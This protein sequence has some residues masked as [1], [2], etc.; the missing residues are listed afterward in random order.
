MT[1]NYSEILFLLVAFCMVYNTTQS[2][3]NYEKCVAETKEKFDT[4]SGFFDFDKMIYVA[5]ALKVVFVFIAYAVVRSNIALYFFIVTQAID[6][7]NFQ[8]IW[9]GE[10]D[11]KR[12][13][14]VTLLRGLDTLAWILISYE[15][16]VDKAI[17]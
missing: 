3:L 8:T 13:H 17:Y 5:L 7:L 4:I 15:I 11:F 16:I 14:R 10:I 6:L 1:I 2:L 9:K 12:L